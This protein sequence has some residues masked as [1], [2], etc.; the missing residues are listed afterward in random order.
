MIWIRTLVFY[1]LF[2]SWLMGCGLVFL[3]TLFL[4]RPFAVKAVNIWL[5]GFLWIS[6]TVLRLDA[7]II[8]RENLQRAPAIFAAKHQSAWE[9]I[10]LYHLLH[11]PAIV[12]KQELLWIPFFGWYLKKLGM[13]SLSRSK[14]KNVKDLKNLL[15]EANQAVSN[16][17]SLLIFPEGTRSMPGKKGTY[18]SGIASLYHHLNIPVIPIAHNAGLFWPR[19]G[20]LKYPGQITVTILPPL[21]PGLPR[22]EFM[23]ILET[24]IETNTNHLVNEGVAYAE[25][26]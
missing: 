17:Q 21:Q 23:R 9:T 10:F 25:R 7:K 26:S 2:C 15:K 8:G 22:N 19:R 13:I 18:Q 14:K 11:D 4:P 1:G 6:K 20:F 16:S 5:Q 3:P 24:Q 12:L